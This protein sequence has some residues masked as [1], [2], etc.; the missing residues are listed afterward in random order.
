MPVPPK[1]HIQRVVRIADRPESRG[2]IVR[3]D[4][5]ERVLPFPEET[6]KALLGALS[7]NDLTAY[8]APEPTYEAIADWMGVSRD[9]ILLTGGSDQAIKSVFEVYIEPGNAVLMPRPT[10]A[11]YSVYCGM[12]EAVQCDLEYT[13]DLMLDT[14]AVCRAIRPEVKLVAL[15][16]PNSP[17]G[18]LFTLKQI[19]AILDRASRQNAIVLVDEAYYPFSDITAVPL[20]DRFDNLIVTRTFSKA[21]GL[22]GARLG[23]VVS[24]P[25]NIDFLRRVKPMYE[26]NGIALKLGRL[27]VENF[28]IVQDYV[29]ATNQGK[30]FLKEKFRNI[31][32]PFDSEGNFLVVRLEPE[33]DID[34]L[35]HRLKNKGFMIK[36]PFSDGPLKDCI[37]ITTGPVHLMADFWSAFE[38]VYDEMKK[39]K[40]QEVLQ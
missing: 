38:T 28:G 21:Y 19:E 13:H 25:V 1:A 27:L 32:R 9:Q 35:I 33:V 3:L 37:R 17:T 5:N 2:N 22:A 18:T 20:I 7:A 31:A 6:L 34:Q 36:G 40:R 12:F 16:N 39:S 14:D 8:P 10:F 30:K 15:P 11:M 4:K 24:S 26:A 29:N 23:F